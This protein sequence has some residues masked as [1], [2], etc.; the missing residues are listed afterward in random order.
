MMSTIKV[1]DKVILQC[2]ASLFPPQAVPMTR[3]KSHLSNFPDP[4]DSCADDHEQGHCQCGAK[5]RK[6][7]LLLFLHPQEKYEVCS[8]EEDVE[9]VYS[10]VEEKLFDLRSDSIG[11][12]LLSALA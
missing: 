1:K 2:S 12:F 3:H 4:P 6:V 8:L 5:G 7:L 11:I 10:H 9:H